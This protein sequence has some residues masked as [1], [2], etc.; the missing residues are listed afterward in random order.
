MIVGTESSFAARCG[1]VLRLSLCFIL[2]FALDATCVDAH[3]IGAVSWQ[4]GNDGLGGRTLFT[5]YLSDNGKVLGFLE[6][7]MGTDVLILRNVNGTIAAETTDSAVQ[8]CGESTGVSLFNGGPKIF[9]FCGGRNLFLIV[10]LGGRIEP[11]Y[12]IRIQTE[13]SFYSPSSSSPTPL[14]LVRGTMSDSRTDAVL[15]VS[16]KDDMSCIGQ[17]TPENNF[18]LCDADPI[19]DFYFPTWVPSTRARP[20]PDRY[21]IIERKSQSGLRLDSYYLPHFASGSTPNVT[22]TL[23]FVDKSKVLHSNLNDDSTAK[24]LIAYVQG[25]MTQTLKL[26]V[27]VFNALTLER[28]AFG[29]IETG[30]SCKEP[31]ILT[32]AYMV[33]CN[34]KN[35][36]IVQTSSLLLNLDYNTLKGEGTP[37]WIVSVS[38]PAGLLFM[39]LRD[40]ND[41]NTEWHRRMLSP[42]YTD[43]NPYHYIKA[44]EVQFIV[45]AENITVLSVSTGKTTLSFN[46]LWKGSAFCNSNDRMAAFTVFDGFLAYLGC[47][48]SGH[49]SLVDPSS[50]KAYYPIAWPSMS[51]FGITPFGYSV[52]QHS[53]VLSNGTRVVGLDL[54]PLLLYSESVLIQQEALS[55]G[56]YDRGRFSLVAANASSPKEMLFY[57]YVYDNTGTAGGR[58]PFPPTAEPVSLSTNTTL[59]EPFTVFFGDRKR[60]IAV[61][62]TPGVLSIFAARDG[63]HVT[64][65]NLTACA[66]EERNQEAGAITFMKTVQHLGSQDN[67]YVVFGGTETCLFEVNDTLVLRINSFQGAQKGILFGTTTYSGYKFDPKPRKLEAFTSFFDTASVPVYQEDGIDAYVVGPNVFVYV[68]AE[69]I[70]CRSV[71]SNIKIWSQALPEQFQAPVVHMAYYNNT[72]F[73][74][75]ERTFFRFDVQYHEDSYTASRVLLQVPVA[76]VEATLF[77]AAV[78]EGTVVL[79]SH[80][81]LFAYDAATGVS[82]WETKLQTMPVPG[83]AKVEVVIYSP[84]DAGGSKGEATGPAYVEVRVTVE[85]LENELRLTMVDIYSL[86]DGA[87]L[88]SISN[89]LNDISGP[90]IWGNKYNTFSTLSNGLVSFR[91]FDLPK[92]NIPE[93]ARRSADSATDVYVPGESPIVP[94]PPPLPRG[95]NFMATAPPMTFS[96]SGD[97]ALISAD[98]KR[99]VVGKLEHMN[100]TYE[101]NVRCF[102]VN[103]PQ[104]TPIRAWAFQSTLSPPHI[105]FMEFNENN[106]AIF[107]HSRVQFY[108]WSTCEEVGES[109]MLSGVLDGVPS[110]VSLGDQNKWIFLNGFQVVAL[111]LST[112]REKWQTG[113]KS[114]LSIRHQGGYIICD[115][116]SNFAVLHADSGTILIKDA[117]EGGITTAGKNF[118]GV[119][120][121]SRGYEAVYYSGPEKLFD[122][123]ISFPVTAGR[124]LGAIPGASDNNVVVLF[125]RMATS[126]TFDSAA[127]TASLVWVSDLHGEHARP[128]AAVYTGAEKANIVIGTKNGLVMLDTKTGKGL[129]NISLPIRYMED[130][131]EVQMLKMVMVKEGTLYGF[132]WNGY[133]VLI[134]IGPNMADA[135]FAF[136][137]GLKRTSQISFLKKLLVVSGGGSAGFLPVEKTYWGAPLLATGMASVGSKVFMA[138]WDWTNDTSVNVVAVT[139]EGERSTLSIPK[140]TSI[141]S[142]S[143]NNAVVFFGENT[144]ISID[145]LNRTNINF[146][147][148]QVCNGTK[149]KKVSRGD[150]ANGASLVWYSGK[151]RDCIFVLGTEGTPPTFL[152]GIVTKFND[153]VNVRYGTSFGVLTSTQI[154]VF[155]HDGTFIGAVDLKNPFYMSSVS[156]SDS[157]DGIFV[158]ISGENVVTCFQVSG[159]LSVWNYTLPSASRAPITYYNGGIFISTEKGP[160]FL[161]LAELSYPCPDRALFNVTRLPVEGRSTLHT[162]VVVDEEYAIAFVTTYQTFYAFDAL[163]GEFIWQRPDLFAVKDVAV[164]QEGMVVFVSTERGGVFL[165][166]FT[167][168]SLLYVPSAGLWSGE[169]YLSPDKTV[170]GFGG[171]MATA[172]EISKY[173]HFFSGVSANR[174]RRPAPVAYRPYNYGPD[175]RPN[176]CSKPDAG[177]MPINT[178]LSSVWVSASRYGLKKATQSVLSMTPG[179]RSGWV[180]SLSEH[181]VYIARALDGTFEEVTRFTLN[182]TGCGVLNLYAINSESAYVSV[183][184]ATQIYFYNTSGAQV[185][186][187]GRA[188]KNSISVVVKGNGYFVNSDNVIDAVSLTSFQP[189]P[190]SPGKA[191]C[192]TKFDLLAAPRLERLLLVCPGVGI[193]I[194]DCTTLTQIGSTITAGSAR[195]SFTTYEVDENLG[196]AV[197]C[198]QDASDVYMVAFMLKTAE[199]VVVHNEVVKGT[200]FCGVRYPAYPSNADPVIVFA[201]L[202]GYKTWAVKGG[203]LKLSEVITNAYPAAITSHGVIY[204]NTGYD[205]YFRV[206]GGSSSSFLIRGGSKPTGSMVIKGADGFQV[207]PLAIIYGNGFTFAVDTSVGRP[208]ACWDDNGMIELKPATRFI[209]FPPFVY[210]T[211]NNMFVGFMVANGSF[212]VQGYFRMATALVDNEQRVFLSQLKTI[213]CMSMDGRVLWNVGISN[214]DTQYIAFSP[215]VL[216]NSDFA[217]VSGGVRAAAVINKRTG[218]VARAIIFERC[219]VSP[220]SPDAQ[221]IVNGTLVYIGMRGWS[222]VHIVDLNLQNTSGNITGSEVKILEVEGALTGL[223]EGYPLLARV[224]YAN[225]L[226]LAMGSTDDDSEKINIAVYRVD[227]VSSSSWTRLWMKP[228]RLDLGSVSTYGYFLY[229]ASAG[230][231]NVYDL[232]TGRYVWGYIFKTS[233]TGPVLGADRTLYVTTQGGLQSLRSPLSM[234]WSMR[235]MGNVTFPQR[236]ANLPITTVGLLRTAYG[237]ILCSNAGGTVAYTHAREGPAS[238]LAWYTEKSIARF[239]ESALNATAVI[240]L[241]DAD[242]GTGVLDLTSG[243]MLWL[244]GVYPSDGVTNGVAS[245]G[246]KFFVCSFAMNDPTC[247]RVPVSFIAPRN[248]LPLYRYESE[249]TETTPPHWIPIY[250]EGGGS[251]PLHPSPRCVSMMHAY[252]PSFADCV[253]KAIATIYTSGRRTKLECPDSLLLIYACQPLLQELVD[254]CPDVAA[255]IMENWKQ[256]TLDKTSPLGLCEP[257]EAEVRCDTTNKSKLSDTCNMVGMTFIVNGYENPIGYTL[258]Y[259]LPAFPFPGKPKNVNVAAVV[260]GV[261]AALVVVAI[262]AAVSMHFYRKKKKVRDA[263]FFDDDVNASLLGSDMNDQPMKIISK[264]NY[265]FSSKEDSIDVDGASPHADQPKQPPPQS[266]PPPHSGGVSALQRAAAGGTPERAAPALAA[267]PKKMPFKMPGKVPPAKGPGPK[268]PPPSAVAKKMVN[269]SPFIDDDL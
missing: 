69:M 178:G 241:F 169:I 215:V 103:D 181:T 212:G 126:I 2:V 28:T 263:R 266:F 269:E 149:L 40:L 59:F 20:N 222:C 154:L 210:T 242:G 147:I 3:I 95:D 49:Y 112:G 81:K 53:V 220:D 107:S 193:Q 10:I 38:T 127:K 123:P 82:L 88:K 160:L 225:H 262:G 122:F 114:C 217:L 138:G 84:E 37:L 22:A 173:A 17:Y 101:Y 99:G 132:S 233:I 176:D 150:S 57:F 4:Y 18:V 140:E 183:K 45:S 157:G 267:G 224:G 188:A 97:A 200:P 16:S 230:V 92:V 125:D 64:N 190:T 235:L 11:L 72:V 85:P 33:Q 249:P 111:D 93:Q 61:S 141:Q 105:T 194:L 44:T 195:K 130:T 117:L 75:D 209:S 245:S 239:G 207:T 264:S 29:S 214:T 208:T 268:L 63:T 60:Y 67:Y 221:V 8:E 50:H 87:L 15:A 255:S 30:V 179:Q 118:A 213:G 23:D 206:Y 216:S 171:V 128:S 91:A 12:V 51:T 70:T 21:L 106:F 34:K 204:H 250:P 80:L 142:S 165:N 170:M 55:A 139:T 199:K 231:L 253:N 43:Y 227:D 261:I 65:L 1:V 48:G 184:C 265:A 236:M 198:G 32:Q 121:G 86:N 259:I 35:S 174:P 223:V 108:S 98:C 143:M 6:I 14:V 234:P 186:M 76:D 177:G 9:I 137:L 248:A 68:K 54:N 237:H 7:G 133:A 156:S 202:N 151:A 124:M 192:T 159:L 62:A 74:V 244:S 27:V 131:N 167:G 71:R 172:I 211:V 146:P 166:P 153:V 119:V 148:P 79:Y 73:V 77:A 226:V 145:D 252:I 116:G 260:F 47:E 134:R 258:G 120:R 180:A 205:Y 243:K 251:R 256:K 161:T 164:I 144:I 19:L 78:N 187:G 168:A 100:A 136:G 110:Y 94:P 42:S 254:A 155:I 13:S 218:E 203:Q 90:V 175:D 24:P 246:A 232:L 5:P 257:T 46:P 229:T 152:S 66:P 115:G 26:A 163:T 196:M 104:G 25:T 56:A 197:A 36:L 58:D 102:N 240:G 182:E 238:K 96:V 158:V 162:K 189:L 228:V 52:D 201:Y 135:F 129:V 113:V 191:K 185:G 89:A 109:I 83:N 31:C 247:R 219:K 41:R 39:P